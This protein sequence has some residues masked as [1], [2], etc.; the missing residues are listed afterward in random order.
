MCRQD[1]SEVCQGYQFLDLIPQLKS[2]IP[3]FLSKA[4]ETSKSCTVIIRVGAITY[5]ADLWGCLQ[6]SS[7]PVCCV[8]DSVAGVAPKEAAAWL[9][10]TSAAGRMN[11]WPLGGYLYGK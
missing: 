11:A 1:S 3:G 5:L 8:T 6:P 9:V 10:C 4:V 7:A 2:R